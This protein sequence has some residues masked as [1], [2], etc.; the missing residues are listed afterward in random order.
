[1]NK[2]LGA[3]ALLLLGS[4]A[5]NAGEIGNTGISWGAETTA[6]Y[7]VD[8]E[9]STW[10]IKPDVTYDMMGWVDLEASTTISIYD[11]TEWAWNESTNLTEPTINFEA[12]RM[13]VDNMEVYAKSGYDFKKDDMTDIVVGATWSF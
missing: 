2:I 13:V 8:T 7:N 6:E 12:S 9:V 5:A 11:G 3:V 10:T 4:F 1:M